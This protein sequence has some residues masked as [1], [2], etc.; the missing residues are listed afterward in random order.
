VPVPA[1]AKPHP[2]PEVHHAPPP[3]PQAHP[4]PLQSSPLQASPNKRAPSP[5]DDSAVTAFV[6][7]AAS[8]ARTHAGE[9]YVT[10][11]AR[12]IAQNSFRPRESTLYTRSGVIVVRLVVARNGQLTDV[13]VA[14]STGA[15]AFDADMMEFIR[16]LSPF[17]PLPDVISGNQ[18]AFTLR[19][20]YNFN[21]DR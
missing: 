9:T 4:S 10:Q 3:P 5:N 15:P 6:N 2:Q 7:P 14:Q 1:P 13:S 19:I 21:P 11:I 20:P 16:R 17:A 8:A 18:A 12:K